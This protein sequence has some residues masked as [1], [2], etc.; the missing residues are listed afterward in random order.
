MSTTELPTVIENEKSGYISCDPH[1]L[2]E[3]M[4]YLLAHPEEAKRM[5]DY[6]KRVAQDRFGLE[7]FKRDWN[8]AFAQV[9]S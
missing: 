7:R 2:S 1:T 9:L 5:G 6:A 3:H 8:A 4:H